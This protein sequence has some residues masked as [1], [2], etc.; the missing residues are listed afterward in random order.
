MVSPAFQM[1]AS[2]GWFWLDAMRKATVRLGLLSVLLGGS[3]VAAV[4]FLSGPLPFSSGPPP[5]AAQYAPQ[6]QWALMETLVNPDDFPLEI[7]YTQNFGK[8]AASATISESG[9]SWK[10]THT[11]PDGV[12]EWSHEA[13]FRFPTLPPVL[14]VYETGEVQLE[15]SLSA[16][17][18]HPFRDRIGATARL[19]ACYGDR[20]R[21][22]QVFCSDETLF[23]GERRGMDGT[24]TQSFR[25]ADPTSNLT[26]PVEEA[27][28]KVE[29]QM[30]APTGGDYGDSV[31]LRV[32][33]LYRPQ[34]LETGPEPTPSSA[35]GA[36][37]TTVPTPSPEL[38]PTP[39]TPSGPMNEDCSID[40]AEF[41][42][43]W[44]KYSDLDDRIPLNDR[45]YEAQQYAETAQRIIDLGLK[46]FN[47]QA[48][49][50]IDAH[51][52][53]EL[54]EYRTAL[55]QNQR[56]NLVKAFIRLAYITYD[57]AAGTP[58]LGQGARGLASSY[59]KLF[60][61]EATALEK[62]GSALKLVQGLSPK[63]SQYALNTNEVTGK[64]EAVGLSGVLD[65]LESF[66]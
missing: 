22:L 62:L 5:V 26:I 24:L 30:R 40:Q 61:Q 13:S 20:Q 58:G 28:F 1:A 23:L 60:S 37:P 66:R 39:F 47:T 46:S 53:Q 48:V 57:T 63:D 25:L 38:T 36:E 15:G 55:V 33:W 45:S 3:L 4:S 16:A 14:Q 18:D 2:R 35:I 29:A 51:A 64:V 27:Y 9:G 31:S 59:G 8:T 21:V 41:A 34:K 32:M 49:M 7:T 19:G 42:Q 10:Q 11:N 54:R 56:N 52:R 12:V 43:E 6:Y 50:E 44:F 17:Q 65:A